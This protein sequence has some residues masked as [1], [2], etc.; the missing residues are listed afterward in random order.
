MNKLTFIAVATMISVSFVAEAATDSQAATAAPIK[1]AAAPSVLVCQIAKNGTYVNVQ[2][3]NKGTAPVAAG[4]RFAFTIIGPTKKTSETYKLKNTL[5]AG[6][7]VDVTNKIPAANVTG[8][9][10][11]N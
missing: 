3:V 5:D 2:A 6:K 7:L 1:T 11:A 10:P 8:C 9:S 4:T